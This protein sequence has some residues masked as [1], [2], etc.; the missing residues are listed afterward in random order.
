VGTKGVGKMASKID[1]LFSSS[2]FVLPEHRELYL[3]LKE[4]EKLIPMPVLGQDELESF[5]YMIRDSAK[6]DYAV[7]V[8]WWNPVKE[9]LGTTYSMWGIV[10]WIDRN[11]CRIKLVNDQETA[12][13]DIDKIV[14][15]RA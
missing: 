7:T 4:D 6:E 14:N 9:G 10:K 3:Q 12:W 13:V 2:R 8:T 15:V 5:H 11:A 1:N